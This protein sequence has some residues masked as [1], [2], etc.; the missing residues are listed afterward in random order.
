MHNVVYYI[1]PVH[2]RF[3]TDEMVIELTAANETLIPIEESPLGETTIRITA[4]SDVLQ[5]N[6]QFNKL[7][8][9][10]YNAI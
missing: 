7:Q 2:E 5:V 4:D 9:L 10:C 1:R 8:I 6:V 3:V